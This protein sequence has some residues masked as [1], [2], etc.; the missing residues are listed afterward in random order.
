MCQSAWS[1]TKPATVGPMAGAKAITKPKMP[2][3]EPRRSTGN[4][5][6]STVMVTGMRMPDVYKRQP[7]LPVFICFAGPE[8]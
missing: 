3:A 1:M 8:T 5:S 7:Q 6:M 4:T 2:M